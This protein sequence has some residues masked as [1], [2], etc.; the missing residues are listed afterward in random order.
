MSG[1]PCGALEKI[2]QDI[3]V[4]NVHYQSLSID[5]VGVSNLN[6]FIELKLLKSLTSDSVANS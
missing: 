1:Q 6:G 4:R 2:P 5:G 3:F